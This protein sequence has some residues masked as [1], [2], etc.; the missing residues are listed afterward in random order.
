MASCGLRGWQHSVDMMMKATVGVVRYPS[1]AAKFLELMA[2]LM[3][4]SSSSFVDVG[5]GLGFGDGDGET[6]PGFV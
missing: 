1:S 4:A 2:S 3:L 6:S 5:D